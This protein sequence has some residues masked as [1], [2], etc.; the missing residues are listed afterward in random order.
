[1]KKLQIIYL[2]IIC[3]LVVSCKVEQVDLSKVY[4][5]CWGS[6]EGNGIESELRFYKDHTATLKSVSIMNGEKI[7]SECDYGFTFENGKLT[8]NP[9][10]ANQS[11]SFYVEIKGDKLKLTAKKKEDTIWLRK[12][13]W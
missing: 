3:F 5:T 10:N 13:T 2:I 1:M 7:H 12:Q 4:E 11:L 9:K 6:K 8:L